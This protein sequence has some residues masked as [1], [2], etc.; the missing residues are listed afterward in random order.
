MVN[1]FKKANNASESV[2]ATNFSEE[3]PQVQ[4]KNNDTV[5]FLKGINVQIEDII[6][7]H[8]K[9]NG[10]HEIL[11][12]LAEQIEKQMEKVLNLTEQT[13]LS[14]DTLFSQGGNLVQITK[15][16]VGKSVEG[17]ESVEGMIKVIENL[18]V[19]TKDTYKN[20]TSLGEKLKEI[21]EIAQL[22]SGIAS[23]T[24]LLA[25]N[26][27]IEAA[28]AGEQGKGF[29]VV[30]DE[31]RKLAEMT[32]ESSS[33]ITKL[34]SDID[35]QTRNVLNSVEK[36]TLVVSEGVKSSRGALEKIEDAL[37]SF[38]CV[39]E[40]A[41]KL[42]STINN[43]KDYVVQTISTIKE[44]DG[45]LTTT[46]RQITGHIEEAGKVDKQLEKSVSKIAEYVQK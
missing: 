41:N 13:S 21:G 44:V 27:A 42:I 38:N 39:E 18:D 33:N 36:S 12:E 43:Q 23:Q 24:N 30:A 9:V 11:S 22:I 45:T 4:V 29:S 3:K 35:S 17:K 2:Q 6:K 14:T 46:N 28:R 40:E 16:T 32:G 37:N 1:F 25:L 34:I 7:Q 31:V 20:I 26:A 10:E 5:E 19:E 15:T 8:N